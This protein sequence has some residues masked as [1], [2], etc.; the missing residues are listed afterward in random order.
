M[1]KYG[2]LKLLSLFLVGSFSEV[3]SISHDKNN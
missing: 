3:F 1:V 2:A